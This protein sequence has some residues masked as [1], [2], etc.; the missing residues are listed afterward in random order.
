MTFLFPLEGHIENLRL[1]SSTFVD[2]FNDLRRKNMLVYCH[3]L[4][5]KVGWLDFFILFF[6]K[7]LVND[8]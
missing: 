8:G 7:E 4:K 5:N 1:F 2:V 6:I 3:M